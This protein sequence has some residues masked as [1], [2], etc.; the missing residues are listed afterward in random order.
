MTFP[1]LPARPQRSAH[2]PQGVCRLLPA[3][4]HRLEGRRQ[5]AQGG[6]GAGPPDAE[7]ERGVAL[8]AQPAVQ[9]AGALAVA[10]QHDCRLLL[11]G[12]AL[13]HRLPQPL[14][15]WPV[16][17]SPPPTHHHCRPQPTSTGASAC[18]LRADPCPADLRPTR[19]LAISVACEFQQLI[20]IVIRFHTAYVNKNSVLITNLS[21]VR[22]QQVDVGQ[23]QSRFSFGLVNT[24][25]AM[26]FSLHPRYSY[27]VKWSCEQQTS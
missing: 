6:G 1:A 2:A 25:F 10:Q 27:L 20:N 13:P 21:K 15:L 19:Y 5:Q 11:P 7:L 26:P 17:R 4:A 18:P 14:L 16:V 23:A 9:V 8:C 22:Q 24:V 3:A 12:R